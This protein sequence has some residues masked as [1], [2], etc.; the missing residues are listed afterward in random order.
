MRLSVYCAVLLALMGV[1]PLLWADEPPGNDQPQAPTGDQAPAPAADQAPGPKP[2]AKQG[3]EQ[4]IHIHHHHHYSG[5]NPAYY[6]NQPVG[7]ANP[8]NQPYPR[9]PS[10]GGGGWGWG[11]WGYGGGGTIAGS[12]LQGLGAA[13]QGAGAYNLATAEAA[14]QAEAARAEYMQNEMSAMN[15]YFL[16]REAN[17]QYREALRL[18]PLTPE[19]IYEINLSRLPKRLRLDQFD[20]VTGKI[21]W[22]DV[23]KTKELDED[24]QKL[25]KLFAERTHDNSGVGSENYHDIQMVVHDAMAKLHDEIKTLSPAEYLLA[26][27]FIDSLAFEARFPPS[28]V[29]GPAQPPA[30]ANGERLG[31]AAASTGEPNAVVP[32]PPRP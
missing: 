15:N 10:Y 24:R 16:A 3:N 9:V 13:A 21:N 26:L 11:G 32:A 29:P 4:Q 7:P 25:D 1:S 30:A 6:Y 27:N 2:S 5:S 28:S 8:A 19:Q 23:L 22:P 12:Y 18:P 20:P 17:R 31:Q 14:R